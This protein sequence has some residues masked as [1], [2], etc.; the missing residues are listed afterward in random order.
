MLYRPM[1][2]NDRDVLFSGSVTTSGKPES[3]LVLHAD[4]THL[5]CFIGG[6]IG[7]GAKVFGIEADLEIAKKLTD[8]CVWAYEATTSGIMPE[9]ATALA[10]ESAEHCPWNETAYWK[11]LDPMGT[12]RDTRLAEYLKAKKQ[13][14][15][16]EKAAQ[17]AA[18]EAASLA[19]ESTT[20]GTPATA[21]K[22]MDTS[23]S[24]NGVTK[25][26][27]PSEEK[28]YDKMSIK[29]E[30]ELE[31]APV[32]F[33]GEALASS[34]GPQEVIEDPMRPL[35]HKEYVES[36]VKTEQLPPGF[37]SIQSAKYILRQV[38]FRFSVTQS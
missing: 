7:M 20:E 5:T 17:V 4:V 1:L 29:A 33:S 26:Q 19:A 13:R 8:G 2:P 22:G 16:D 27:L 18:A 28:L 38:P 3:D 9:G 23:S 30:T 32:G 31:K 21:N 24:G 14:E 34:A 11:A 35:S 10:C 15:A 6:M 25:R 36:R 37:V 12:S